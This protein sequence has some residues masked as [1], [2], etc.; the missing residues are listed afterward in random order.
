MKSIEPLPDSL[1]V[2]VLIQQ[3]V[4]AFLGEQAQPVDERFAVAS[5]ER[6]TGCVMVDGPFRGAV[7]VTA[8]PRLARRLGKI[9][10]AEEE[11]SIEESREAFA[12]FTNV[13]GGNL[14]ALLSMMVGETCHLCLPIVAQGSI[15][16]PGT[17]R[18]RETDFEFGDE[19]LAVDI[20]E[21][22]RE[23]APSA[24]YS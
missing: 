22:G 3:V 4:W 2:A 24:H 19:H 23:T 16:I 13:I 9:M 17:K 20:F 6:W 14:K 21:L 10:F 1:D 5:G 11:P 15:R 8:S 12:E 7:T 18:C